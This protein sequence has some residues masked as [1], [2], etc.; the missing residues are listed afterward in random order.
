LWKKKKFIVDSLIDNAGIGSFGFFHESE[1]G[2]E[3][4]LIN[5]NITALTKITRY[6]I[7]DMVEY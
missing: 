6:F 2:F 3:E 5:V 4:K 1:N 7:K